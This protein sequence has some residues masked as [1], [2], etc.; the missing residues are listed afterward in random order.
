[1]TT[2]S[3]LSPALQWRTTTFLT[4]VFSHESIDL[5]M[6]H[7]R[8]S[9]GANASGQ[10]KSNTY[11][12]PLTLMYIFLHI[13]L[14]LQTFYELAV[15]KNFVFID[16]VTTTKGHFEAS[17]PHQST[18]SYKFCQFQNNLHA[19]DVMPTKL[20]SADRWSDCFTFWL[21]LFWCKNWAGGFYPQ[22]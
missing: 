8:S 10:P 13:I 9:G 21:K 11:K 14:Q 6:L 19:F 2:P 18:L 17:Q 7:R 3:L 5:H 4:C 12:F 20:W 1:M 16:R 22:A 15:D